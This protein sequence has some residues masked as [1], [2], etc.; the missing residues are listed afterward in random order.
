MRA[1]IGPKVCFY[2]KITVVYKGADTYK[3][4]EKETV[5]YV[6]PYCPLIRVVKASEYFG[7]NDECQHGSDEG[8]TN[9]CP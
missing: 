7:N 2:Q 5:E 4:K 1:E 8:K 9:K 3:Q 6:F